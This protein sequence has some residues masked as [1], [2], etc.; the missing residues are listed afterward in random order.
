[1][2]PK[3]FAAGLRVEHPQEW[4][5][6]ALYGEKE[7]P[8]LGPA[9]YK[10]THTCGNGRGVYSFC[11]CPGGYVVNASS[12]SGLLCVNGMS[13]SAR[14]GA[15]ANS[16]IIVTVTPQDFPEAGIWPVYVSSGCWRKPHSWQER[17]ASPYSALR[18]IVRIFLRPAAAP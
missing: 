5:N 15:N 3:A 16:A 11:M 6:Q 14:D 17:A 2:Q 1:M 18:I 12:E 8:V 4:I 9:A 7:N 10:V 13:Y